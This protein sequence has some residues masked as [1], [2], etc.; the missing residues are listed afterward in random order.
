[1]QAVSSGG[2]VNTSTNVEY[3]LTASSTENGSSAFGLRKP[4]HTDTGEKRGSVRVEDF[5][6]WAYDRGIV[7]IGFHNIGHVS[8]PFFHERVVGQ[9]VVGVIVCQF[10]DGE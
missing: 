10:M 6:E 1:M 4:A 3:T 5:L 8:P 7:R 2:Q 9:V